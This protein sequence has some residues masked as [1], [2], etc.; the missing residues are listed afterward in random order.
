MTEKTESDYYRFMHFDADNARK[1]LAYYVKYFESGPVLELA[2]GPG[3]FLTLLAEAGIEGSGVD[4]DDGMVAQAR[5]AGHDVVLADATDYLAGLPDESVAGIFAAHFVEHLPAEQAQQIYHQA[6]RV[7]IPGGQFVAVVPNAAC[8]S[9]M[10]YDFW[11]DP[12]HVRFYDP[13]ALEFFAGQA[14]LSVLDSGGNPDNHPGAPPPLRVGIFPPVPALADRLG[15]MMQLAHS[16]I[17]NRPTG[18][19]GHRRPGRAG[20]AESDHDEDPEDLLWKQLGQLIA[21]VDN[22]IQVLQHELATTRAAYERL[23]AQLY[24]PNEVF[25]VAAKQN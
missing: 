19:Q 20:R 24:P 11:R 12:T 8:L 16:V 5:A 3:V 13:V 15:T 4:I 9:I 25:V 1:V 6:A 23:L 17:E 21:S 7:L 18:R 22:G 14:G 10:G 2:C